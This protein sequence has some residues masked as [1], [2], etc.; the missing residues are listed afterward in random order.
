MW[1]TTPRWPGKVAGVHRPVTR[2]RLSWGCSRAP[3]RQPAIR[4][5]TPRSTSS[6]R[7]AAIAAAAT[8]LRRRSPP[9]CRRARPSPPT[10]SR[11]TRRARSATPPRA[12]T[13]RYSV[14]GTHQGVTTCLNCHG[15][16]V[17]S[18][19]ANITIVRSPG[20]H[21]PVGNL[22]CNGSGC[23]TTAKVTAGGFRLGAASVN[24]P[25]L[26]V[27]G[28]T[29]VAGQVAACTTCHETAPF[30][31]MIASTNDHGR[32]LA[33]ERD[34]RQ[35]P[36]DLGRLQH[37]PQHDADVHRERFDDAE[38]GQSHP[39]QRPVRAVPHHRRQLRPVFG[40]GHAPGR[41]A[42]ASAA[43]RRRSRTPSPTSRSCR[44]RTTTSRSATSTATARAATRPRKSRPAGSTLG[45]ASISAPTLNGAGHTTV[46][47]AVAA[48][49]SCH[50]TAPYVGMVAS[51][52]Q[53]RRR[54]AADGLRQ[55]PPDQR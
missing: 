46:A 8:A 34:A 45:A 37:L 2:P 32:R 39:D 40:D 14:T 21:I 38:A 19:F 6:I 12:T 33:P 20:N 43:T 42:I 26:N 23:H 48:C 15:A 10:T 17:A 51:S 54:F 44:R 52:D 49:T 31:G 1:R 55:A 5:R 18:T 28:H 35:G 7:P 29:T 30:V 25:T 36:S 53:Y 41:A 3:V 4:A 27:A 9:T 11:P 47:A 16:S 24:A 50:E 13:Q 22:D